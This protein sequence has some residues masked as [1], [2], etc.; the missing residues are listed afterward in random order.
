MRSLWAAVKVSRARLRTH[1]LFSFSVVLFVFLCGLTREAVL[2][3][4]C[5]R[6][7]FSVD[8]EFVIDVTQ[9]EPDRIDGDVQ[10]CGSSFVTVAFDQ[11]AQQTSLVRRQIVVILSLALSRGIL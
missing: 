11:H 4:F 5:D 6:F 2:E 10:F 7:G 3:G 8:L 1:P 9:V